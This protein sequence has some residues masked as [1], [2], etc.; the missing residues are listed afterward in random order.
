M[1]YMDIIWLQHGDYMLL[2]FF[3]DDI[4][5]GYGHY[6]GLIWTCFIFF[7]LFFQMICGFEWDNYLYMTVEWDCFIGRTIS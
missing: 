1:E 6:T 7:P 5:F 4:W 2:L 3:P